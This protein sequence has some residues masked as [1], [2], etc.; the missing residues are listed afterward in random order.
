[1]PSNLPSPTNLPMCKDMHGVAGLGRRVGAAN[2]FA[3]GRD[4][5]VLARAPTNEGCT[6]TR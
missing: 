2:A 5:R 1:V 6:L 4:W 3:A